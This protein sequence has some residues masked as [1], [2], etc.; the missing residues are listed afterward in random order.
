VSGLARTRLARSVHDAGWSQ[1]LRLMETKQ[2]GNGR[3]FAGSAGSSPPARCARVRCEGWAKPLQ[4][5][6]VDVRSV[7]DVHDRDV[8]RARN[9]LAAGR[10]D[11]SSPAKPEE[12]TP[13][14]S[15]R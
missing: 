15:R 3:T 9:I 12:T 6:R 1:L 2:R 7:R 13:C 14:G 11:K 4:V 10:A 8:N 5:R